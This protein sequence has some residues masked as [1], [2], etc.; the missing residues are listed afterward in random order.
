MF[1]LVVSNSMSLDHS[2]AATAYEK[3]DQGRV[4]A[5]EVIRLPVTIDA[6]VSPQDTLCVV[7]GG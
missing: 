6:R 7:C 1:Q 4:M 3:T 2:N 5:R